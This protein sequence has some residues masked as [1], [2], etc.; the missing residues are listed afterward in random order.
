MI[1]FWGPAPP[2][3][4]GTSE[5]IVTSA[6][7]RPA[8]GATPIPVSEDARAVPA[9]YDGFSWP[10]P[11]GLKGAHHESDRS[12]VGLKWAHPRGCGELPSWSAPF[13]GCCLIAGDELQVKVERPQRSEDVRP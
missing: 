9:G 10:H 7:G 1:L 8:P 5:R 12:N 2:G 4:R 6:P 13:L 3:L 11:D